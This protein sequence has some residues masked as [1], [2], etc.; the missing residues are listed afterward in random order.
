VDVR[1]YSDT[2]TGSVIDVA[3][4]ANF[5]GGLGVVNKVEGGATSPPSVAA[6]NHAIDN[7][8]N[9]RDSV[10]LKFSSDISLTGVTIGWPGSTGCTVPVSGTACDTDVSIWAYKGS[11]TP[12]TKTYANLTSNGWI[13]VGSYANLAQNT[14]RLVNGAATIN[15]VG[16]TTATSWLIAAYSS[17]TGTGTG[18]DANNDFVK[19]LTVYAVT[20]NN[21]VPEPASVGLLVAALSGGVWVRRSRKQAQA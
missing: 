13:L 2:A 17:A 20:N 7:Y 15:S 9:I 4:V 10:L 12:E 16:T 18:L 1:G 3:Y 8:N 21:R 14:A 5:S 6:P 19:L 11:A